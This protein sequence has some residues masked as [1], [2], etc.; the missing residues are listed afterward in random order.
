MLLAHAN[1]YRL[2]ARKYR[3]TQNGQVGLVL[4]IIDER[5]KTNSVDDVEAAKRAAAW[6]VGAYLK[7]FQVL[8]CIFAGVYLQPL[9]GDGNW[10]A[11]MREVTARRYASVNASNPLPILTKKEQMHI[12]G[13]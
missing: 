9:L 1:V 6:S 3:P 4:S 11:V 5:P 2:Y 10:P 12:Q 13:N 7:N 8:L